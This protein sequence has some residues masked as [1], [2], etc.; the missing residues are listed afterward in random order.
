MN[1]RVPRGAYRVQA[2]LILAVFA[3]FVANALGVADFSQVLYGRV[4]LN[5]HV[6][7]ALLGGEL[8]RPLLGPDFLALLGVGAVLAT[9]LPLL[10]PIGASLLTLGAM[11]PPFWVAWSYPAPPPLVPLEYT[12]LAIL[13]LFSSNVLMSYFAETHR[14]RQ[15]VAAFGQYV[16]PALV[17]TLSRDPQA[18][19]MA[20]ESRELSVLFCDI[21]RFS[22]ISEDL[23]PLTLANMLNHYLSAMTEVLH[24][25]GATIDKYIGDAVMAF[26]GA[27]VRQDDH[28]ARA[29][30]AALAMQRRM[31]ALRRTC[32]DRGWPALEI[33]I[34]V[35]S[36]TVSVGNMG[37]RYRVAYT[38]LGDA[39]N[40]AARLEALTRLYGVDILVSDATRAGAPGVR[41]REIDH[42]RV[43]GKGQATRIFQPLDGTIPDGDILAREHAA[44]A[45]YYTGDWERARAA[46]E[47]L[48]GSAADARWYEVMLQRMDAHPRPQGWD[49]V[50]AFG[51]ASEVTFTPPHTN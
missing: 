41:F 27:P 8:A 36:G 5:G 17:D 47:A 30:S 34:G 18:L 23:D 37:S 31:H 42:V 28:A 6:L 13:V 15:I 10:P 40:L 29:V 33:G 38:V 49:G 11:A 46:F 16:P 14:R 39:V 2:A 1:P 24:A 22:S 45:A 9:V 50:V 32:A 12:L 3:V 26:W 43:K 21:K 20:G 35:A 25:H 19:S 4:A 48:R 51:G 44:L 7:A